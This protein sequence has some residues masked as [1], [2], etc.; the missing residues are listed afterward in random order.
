MTPPSTVTPE[1]TTA[2]DAPPLDVPFLVFTADHDEADAS[3]RFA[4]RYGQP[5]DRIYELGENLYLG[6]L[7]GKD[8]P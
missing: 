3:R 5:P 2:A 7:P 6:P 4:A 8:N 1:P